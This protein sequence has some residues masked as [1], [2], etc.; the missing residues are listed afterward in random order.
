MSSVC[1][2][3]PALVALHHDR[4]DEHEGAARAEVGLQF[5]VDCSEVAPDTGW[6]AQH[7]V[8]EEGCDAV[9]MTRT[10]ILLTCVDS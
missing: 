6:L 2:S 5:G 1:P 7:P 3:V 8:E 4:G 9:K 10:M